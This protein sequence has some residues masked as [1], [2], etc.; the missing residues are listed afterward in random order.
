M[1]LGNQTILVLSMS[2]DA[3]EG[4]CSLCRAIS[5][6]STAHS[7]IFYSYGYKNCI[8]KLKWVQKSM[9]EMSIDY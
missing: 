5:R 1:R 6:Q 2:D 9:K 3:I 7:I 8:G 4:S